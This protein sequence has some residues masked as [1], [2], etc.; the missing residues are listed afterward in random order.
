PNRPRL[1]RDGDRRGSR[2]RAAVPRALPAER[3]GEAAVTATGRRVGLVCPTD[4]EHGPLIPWTHGSDY[5]WHC[6]HQA[7]DGH[8][9]RPQTRAFF[10]TAEAERGLTTATEPTVHPTK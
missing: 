3:P 10:T 9:D 1:H 6:P 8:G 2:P 7:H 4:P 5:G